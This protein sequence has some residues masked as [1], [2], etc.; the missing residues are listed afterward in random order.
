MRCGHGVKV[1]YEGF[2]VGVLVDFVVD[3][4]LV[5]LGHVDDGRAC[6]LKKTCKGKV[7]G[8]WCSVLHEEW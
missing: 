6:H 4:E 3:E 1:C 2:N 8:S 5:A 7:V